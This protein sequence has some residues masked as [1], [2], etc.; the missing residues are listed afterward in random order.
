MIINITSVTE[1]IGNRSD[2]YIEWGVV[3]KRTTSMAG[4]R[5]L[6]A[7][8]TQLRRALRRSIRTDYPWEARPIAQIEVLQTLRDT[9]PIRLGDLAAR[10]N[11]AQST[12]S[13]LVSGL[14]SGEL[15]SRAVDTRDRRASAIE[16]S[17]AGRSYLGEWDAAHQR[18]IGS[19]LHTLDVAERHAVLAAL[20]ALARLV[21][22]LNADAPSA[23]SR[24]D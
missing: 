14:V 1:Q 10:L 13:T 12:V 17:D 23:D 20:P 2:P 22:A 15:V 8:V 21:D 19:A 9:G 6:T 7:V 11:L 5:E 18:R 4:A 16:L 3:T 24:R